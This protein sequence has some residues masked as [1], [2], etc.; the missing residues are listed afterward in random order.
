MIAN[1]FDAVGEQEGLLREI[2]LNLGSQRRFPGTAQGEIK[3][4]GCDGYHDDKSSQQLEENAIL[5]F[6]ASKR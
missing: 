1:G 2:A 3:N 6:G 5:H 4:K